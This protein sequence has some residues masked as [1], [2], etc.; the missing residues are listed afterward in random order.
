MNTNLEGREIWEETTFPAVV[1]GRPWY[2]RGHSALLSCSPLY[3]FLLVTISFFRL[4]PLRYYKNKKCSCF[5]F[6][7][8]YDVSIIFKIL[9]YIPLLPIGFK[10]F[11]F[12]CGW[13]RLAYPSSKVNLIFYDCLHYRAC[14]GEIIEFPTFLVAPIIIWLSSGQW[15]I[16]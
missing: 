2:H 14:K 9:S 1:W 8:R 12:E 16:S 15:E 4:W 5:I 11:L 13:H 10:S 3:P 7:L 6:L